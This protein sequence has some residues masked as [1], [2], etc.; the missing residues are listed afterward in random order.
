MLAYL[1]EMEAIVVAS[2]MCPQI[3]QLP[4]PIEKIL[5]EI[6]LLSPT[7]K[8]EIRVFDRQARQ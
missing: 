8:V 7:E 1:V 6:A 5:I 4:K 3:L 2:R